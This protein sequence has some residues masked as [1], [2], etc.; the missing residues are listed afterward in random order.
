MQLFPWL[1]THRFPGC[2]AHLGAGAGVA[3]YAGLAG[4]DTEDAK[5]AQLDA[6][7]CRKGLFQTLEDGIYSRLGLGAGQ[8]CA[9]DHVMNDVLLNQSGYLASE[10]T[11]PRPTQLMVQILFQLSNV[12]HFLERAS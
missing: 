5:P 1:E 6:L 12:A 9:L 11:V 3:A 10:K 8:P 2:D 7:A 4:A